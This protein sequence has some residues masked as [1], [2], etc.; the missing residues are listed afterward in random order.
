M[1]EI[2][3]RRSTRK[4]LDKAVE[5][6][7][8]ERILRTAMQ[9]PTGRN[10]QD[11]EFLVVTDAEKR[12]A[13]S[14]ASPYSVCAKN[15]PMLI[16]PLANMERTQG[17]DLLWT[18]DLGA[19]TQTILIQTEAEGLGATWLACWPY[20]DRMACI[21]TAFALPEHIIPYAIIP[22]GYKERIKPF[23]D[24]YDPEKVHWE[25]Y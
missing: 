25:R 14:Q 18:C 16:I 7:K 21:R 23:E 19:A 8:V 9:S 20:A 10:A 2:M 22:I 13:A 3:N 11:W 15:A 6:E 17:D 5:P 24:R 12:D 1:N 4:F